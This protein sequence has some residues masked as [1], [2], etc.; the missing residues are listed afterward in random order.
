ML[1]STQAHAA[2]CKVARIAELHAKDP[3][4]AKDEE[5]TNEEIKQAQECIWDSLTAG[6]AKAPTPWAKDFTSWTN[7]STQAY[8]S[9]THGNRYVMNFAD[10][11]AKDYA[12]YEKSGVLPVGSVLAKPSF[13]INGKGEVKPGPLFFMEKHEDGFDKEAQNWKYSM[14]TP[15]GKFNGGAA[16]P[17]PKGLRFC[18]NC[19][20]NTGGE[21]DS[22]LYVP[23]DYRIK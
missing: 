3:K 5:P 20:V 12:K 23:E 9:A 4:A 6:Y 15:T 8:Q 14:V 16:G 11:V 19:H 22:L 1:T 18:V 10:S 7:V 13:S 21:Y 2:D 17:T